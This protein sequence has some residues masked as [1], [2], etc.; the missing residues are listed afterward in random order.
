MLFALAL[1]LLCSF[2]HE[3]RDSIERKAK[4]EIF[5]RC[6]TDQILGK[7][8]H[9]SNKGGP[10]VPRHGQKRVIQVGDVC[11][12]REIY[13]ILIQFLHS[14]VRSKVRRWAFIL[15]S[16]VPDPLDLKGIADKVWTLKAKILTLKDEILTLKDEI[17]TLNVLKNQILKINTARHQKP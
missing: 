10:A 1:A 14:I 5:F 2:V 3:R 11:H 8:Q 9:N 16:T 4:R 13:V 17:W 7:G 12:K 6:R 15:S